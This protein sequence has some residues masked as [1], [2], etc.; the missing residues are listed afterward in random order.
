MIIWITLC[1]RV[2][3]LQRSLK[4]FNWWKPSLDSFSAGFYAST[5]VTRQLTQHN[6]TLTILTTLRSHFGKRNF[7]NKQNKSKLKSTFSN[8]TAHMRYDETN[9]KIQKPKQIQRQ[10]FKW[11]PT[12]IVLYS[13]FLFVAWFFFLFCVM[14]CFHLLVLAWWQVRLRW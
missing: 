2:T 9:C 5:V 14:F 11:K 3:V 4:M 6:F 12:S 10:Q 8:L 1:I 7:T 13:L